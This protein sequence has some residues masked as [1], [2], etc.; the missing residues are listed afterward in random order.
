VWYYPDAVTTASGATPLIDGAIYVNGTLVCTSD[1]SISLA[2]QTL[3]SSGAIYV[4][5][6]VFAGNLTVDISESP[7]LNDGYSAKLI[8]S[9]S[10][11][12][13]AAFAN[14]MKKD[15]QS[16][17]RQITLTSAAGQENNQFLLLGVFTVE[18]D[19][20]ASGSEPNTI[21]IVAGVVIGLLVVIAIFVVIRGISKRHQ[22]NVAHKKWQ[23]ERAKADADIQAGGTGQQLRVIEE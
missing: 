19:T 16:N 1:S 18:S 9:N 22:R 7:S 12:P 14:F 21:V 11:L 15:T 2:V 5:S 13:S 17:C 23:E 6:V 20:C 3:S 10:P 8:I 4:A